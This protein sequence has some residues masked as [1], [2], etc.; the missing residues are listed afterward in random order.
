M[1]EAK[2]RR[3]SGEAK[4]GIC[5]AAL[6]VYSGDD[7]RDAVLASIDFDPGLLP[8]VAVGSLHVLN[9]PKR[10]DEQDRLISRCTNEL[11]PIEESRKVAVLALF[12]HLGRVAAVNWDEAK[13]KLP[14][15]HLFSVVIQDSDEGYHFSYTARS[16]G[17]A[18]ETSEALAREM[19]IPGPTPH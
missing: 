15:A 2:R 7:E 4:N 1:V 5:P 13:R 11:L 8:V 14:D 12:G 3:E 17:L 6:F 10:P 9:W 16:A 19:R 18:R